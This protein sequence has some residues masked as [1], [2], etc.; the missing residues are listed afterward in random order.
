MK[1]KSARKRLLGLTVVRDPDPTGQ[2]T[3]CSA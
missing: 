2:A 3:L 1:F